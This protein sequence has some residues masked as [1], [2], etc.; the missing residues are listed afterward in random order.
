VD[1]RQPAAVGKGARKRVVAHFGH[2][3]SPT[4]MGRF[5][6]RMREALAPRR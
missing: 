6:V 2:R 4:V 5:V 1:H 3:I